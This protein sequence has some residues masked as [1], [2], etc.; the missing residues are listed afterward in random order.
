MKFIEFAHNQLVKVMQ[1]RL[2]DIKKS[3]AAIRLHEFEAKVAA[4]EHAAAEKIRSALSGL[5]Q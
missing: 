5:L 3:E 1:A 2:D 4:E